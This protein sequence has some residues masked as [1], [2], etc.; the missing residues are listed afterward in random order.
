MDDDFD[1]M[2]IWY[3]YLVKPLIGGAMG[4][5]FVL[6]FR[7]GLVPFLSTGEQNDA[8]VVIVLVSG[9]AGIF[10]EDAMRAFRGLFRRQ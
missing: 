10:A 3:L 2:Q 4:F 6:L 9:L 8:W 5:L 7:F 1:W